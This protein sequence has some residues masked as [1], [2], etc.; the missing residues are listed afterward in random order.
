V[1]HI[2]DRDS[3]W[4]ERALE[5]ALTAIEHLKAFGGPLG[6]KLLLENIQNDVTTP[7]NLVEII[8]VG[9][10]A[11]VGVCFDIGHAHLMEGVE[12]SLATLLPLIGSSHLHDNHHDRDAHLWPGDGTITWDPAVEALKSAPRSPAALLEIHY[13]L[14]ETPDMIAKRAA[15][16]F[17]KFGI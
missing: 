7:A 8:R 13:E 10:F 9:H 11:N 17:E 6:V 1:L 12:T 5:H 3:E 15:E 4:D 14:G 2:G 16:T